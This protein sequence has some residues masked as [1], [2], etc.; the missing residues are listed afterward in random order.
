MRVGPQACGPTLMRDGLEKSARKFYPERAN[1][2]R[3]LQTKC[4]AGQSALQR[5]FSHEKVAIVMSG[6]NGGL[7]RE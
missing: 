7:L 1:P 5:V 6:C 4:G 2:T 3:F